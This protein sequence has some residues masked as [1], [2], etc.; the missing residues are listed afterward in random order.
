ME[1]L[2]LCFDIM[3]ET[4]QIG[5]KQH[6]DSSVKAEDEATYDHIVKYTGFLGGIQVLTLLVGVVRNKLAAV[7]LNTA[8]V[9]L[10]S[11]FQ[12]VLN[13]MQNTSGLGISFSSIKEIS[14]YYGRGD[15]EAI[16]RHVCVVRTWGVWTG[17]AGM[18]LCVLLSPLISFCAFEDFSHSLSI[19]LLSPV[20]AFMSVTAAELAVLKA[21]RRLKRVA[22]VS[23]F[24]ALAVR[25]CSSSAGSTT[26]PW[27]IVW[28]MPSVSWTP[29]SKLQWSSCPLRENFLLSLTP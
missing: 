5:G 3:D 7:L 21:V 18:L 20:V 9:G 23:V 12:N 4:S 27:P 16:A 19:C 15:A 29:H 8:G 10:S 17:L 28:P 14:E 13:F 22:L 6:V 24:S 11:L 1:K 26:A 25:S 2:Y